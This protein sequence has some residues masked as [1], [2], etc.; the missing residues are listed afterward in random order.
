[1]TLETHRSFPSELQ[2]LVAAANARLSVSHAINGLG[3]RD[4]RFWKEEPTDITNRL[5]WPTVIESMKDRAEE[6]RSLAGSAKKRGIHDLILPGM[7]GCSLG[8]AACIITSD[9]RQTHL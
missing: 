4:H 1:M 3:A 9:Q 8:S 2:S 5:G 6:L 7:G